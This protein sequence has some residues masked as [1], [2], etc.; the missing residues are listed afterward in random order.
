M[1]I[2]G[3]L[4]QLQ[5]HFRSINLWDECAN[6]FI[7]VDFMP[8]LYWIGRDFAWELVVEK[9]KDPMLESVLNFFLLCRTNYVT[10]VVV[11]DGRPYP[12]KAETQ[13]ARKTKRAEGNVKLNV[14]VEIEKKKESG[15]EEGPKLNMRDKNNKA[16]SCLS[17]DV[18]F[19]DSCIL[20][21]RMNIDY[22]F[23]ILYFVF[24][25]FYVELFIYFFIKINLFIVERSGDNYFPSPL[26]G[27]SPI[28][29]SSKA[30]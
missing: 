13:A 21:V 20:K 28:G 15:E 27:R 5:Q 17:F 1:G 7:L 22:Y 30:A 2:K 6:K 23:F 14:Q 24:F 10:P 16:M 26:R 11:L 9:K 18:P 8:L 12:P 25:I 19:L 4:V 3:A 29:I